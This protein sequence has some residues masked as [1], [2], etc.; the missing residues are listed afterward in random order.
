M[1]LITANPDFETITEQNVIICPR[2]TD[3]KNCVINLIKKT[4]NNKV[5][6]FKLIETYNAEFV[7]MKIFGFIHTDDGEI[8]PK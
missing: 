1:F 5:A 8:L 3:I 2:R 4:Q 7:D 6:V